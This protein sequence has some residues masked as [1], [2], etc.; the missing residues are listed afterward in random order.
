MRM[1]FLPIMIVI[2]FAMLFIKIA[3]IIDG[4]DKFS[5]MFLIADIKAETPKSD[6]EN[7]PKDTSS[8]EDKTDKAE[9]PTSKAEG[10]NDKDPLPIS[11]KRPEQIDCQK[12]QFNDIELEILQSLAKRRNEIE[13]WSKEVKT[14]EALLKAAEMKIDNKLAKLQDLQAQVNKL[15]ASYNEKEDIKI[16]SLVKI[17]ENMK[18]KDAAK[19][20]NGLDNEILL[21]VIDRMKQAK[22]AP[23]MAQMDPG[24]VTEITMEYANQKTLPPVPKD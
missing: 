10:A 16:N 21:Q 4:S 20:F 2:S 9:S 5:N 6:D 3:D 11:N 23:I 17:Y 19:I 15:L 24:K 7:K 8:H 13:S 12:Q 14:K 1:R 18:S 22:S